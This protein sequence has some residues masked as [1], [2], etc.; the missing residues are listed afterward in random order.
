MSHRKTQQSVDESTNENAKIETKIKTPRTFQL[1]ILSPVLLLSVSSDCTVVA[2]DIWLFACS[3]VS[4][5]VACLCIASRWFGCNCDKLWLSSLHLSAYYARLT[6]A[7]CTELSLNARGSFR[8]F[9][10]TVKLNMAFYCDPHL[11]LF[12]FESLPCLSYHWIF[13]LVFVGLFL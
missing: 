9:L 11:L 8:I 10:F 3:F 7:V 12:P 13:H 5:T 4:P 6:V 2:I 1:H